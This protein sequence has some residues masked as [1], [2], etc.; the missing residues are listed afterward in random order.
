MHMIYGYDFERDCCYY[1]FS[2]HLLVHGDVS[3]DIAVVM[4]SVS[5]LSDFLFDARK[6]YNPPLIC[7][8]Y[9]LYFIFEGQN[10]NKK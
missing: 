3:F 4:A 8:R 9:L 7:L 10:E 5:L 1:G 6:D 2:M